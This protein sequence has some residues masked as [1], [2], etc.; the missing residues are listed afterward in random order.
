VTATDRL[1]IGQRAHSNYDPERPGT[2]WARY[3]AHGREELILRKIYGRKEIWA[4]SRQPVYTHIVLAIYI[5][6]SKTATSNGAAI[7][8]AETDR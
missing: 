6:R 3:T 5:L 2:L 4:L 7:Q 8:L 1:S